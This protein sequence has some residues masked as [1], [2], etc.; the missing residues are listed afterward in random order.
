MKR[1][2]HVPIRRNMEFAGLLGAALLLGLLA[3]SQR[4]PLALGTSFARSVDYALIHQ[5]TDII[6]IVLWLGFVVEQWL[7]HGCAI[8]CWLLESAKHWCS[9]QPRTVML[10]CATQSNSLPAWAVMTACKLIIPWP[11]LPSSISGLG[12]LYYGL[13]TWHSVLATLTFFLVALS[14]N[15]QLP[16]SSA[17]CR[18]GE[19]AES[20]ARQVNTVTIK[21][22]ETLSDVNRT[23]RM[24]SSIRTMAARTGHRFLPT[25]KRKVRIIEQM[26]QRSD[27]RSGSDCAPMGSPSH[28]DGGMV[29]CAQPSMVH[30][31]V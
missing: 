14:L 30:T 16:W 11:V 19:I 24:P 7:T 31:N 15:P 13:V 18:L 27:E 17:S 20:E 10:H 8:A 21:R 4:I 22:R 5:V 9:T 6:L 28:Y 3:E 29:M 26:C 25:A 2:H 23:S 12:P 1:I